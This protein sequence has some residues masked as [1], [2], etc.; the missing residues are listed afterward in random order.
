[1]RSLGLQY[2]VFFKCEKKTTATLMNL[3]L[4][5]LCFYVTLYI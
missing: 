5:Q 4:C 2:H 1:M 3:N